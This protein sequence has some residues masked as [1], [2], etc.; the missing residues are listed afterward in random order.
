MQDDDIDH[1]KERTWILS[2][3]SGDQLWQLIMLNT[4]S[5]VGS[6]YSFCGTLP[7]WVRTKPSVAAILAFAVGL[8]VRSQVAM[9]TCTNPKLQVAHEL[10]NQ[11]V[12]P[13]DVRQRETRGDELKRAPTEELNSGTME[14]TQLRC[15]ENGETA[16]VHCVRCRVVFLRQVVAWIVTEPQVTMLKPWRGRPH[17][18]IDVVAQVL[19]SRCL[20][21]TNPYLSCLVVRPSKSKQETSSIRVIAHHRFDPSAHVESSEQKQNVSVIMSYH[22]SGTVALPYHDCGRNVDVCDYNRNRDLT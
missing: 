1:V 13:S 15:H 9:T 18:Y 7:P 16:R 2:W 12:K 11:V 19:I 14:V 21:S 20:A 8:S 6:W 4:L 5:F 22:K 3:Y 17:V 10:E